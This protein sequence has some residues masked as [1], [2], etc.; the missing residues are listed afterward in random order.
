[1]QHSSKVVLSIELALIVL[2]FQSIAIY[3]SINKLQ[4]LNIFLKMH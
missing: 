1:M 3:F 4:A 2:Y